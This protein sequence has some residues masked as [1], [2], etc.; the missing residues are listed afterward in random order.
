MRPLLAR[1][2]PRELASV[3]HTGVTNQDSNQVILFSLLV[4]LLLFILSFSTMS[5]MAKAQ[6][7]KGDGYMLEAKKTLNK[8][9]WFASAKEKNQEDAAELFVQAATAYK[10]GGLHQEAGDAYTEAAKIYR[11]TLGN[12]NDASKCLSQAGT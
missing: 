8:K 6:K 4:L 11:D 3:S 7:G 10:V 2:L 12:M 1:A 9:A 5:A